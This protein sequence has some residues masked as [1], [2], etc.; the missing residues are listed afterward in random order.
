M[1]SFH[2]E[3]Q[4]A[5]LQNLVILATCHF[6][7]KSLAEE[8]ARSAFLGNLRRT[9]IEISFYFRQENQIPSSYISLLARLRGSQIPFKFTNFCAPFNKYLATGDL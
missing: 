8:I 5:C 4:N 6:K 3:P 1:A 9:L 2:W 7:S